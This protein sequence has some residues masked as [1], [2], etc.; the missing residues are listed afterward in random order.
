MAEQPFS[1]HRD[2]FKFLHADDDDWDEQEYLADATKKM[3]VIQ[4][5][6]AGHDC[7][8]YAKITIN[9]E[10]IK[11]QKNGKGHDRGVHIVIINPSSGKVQYAVVFDTYEGS[12]EFDDF[13]SNRIP[14]GYIVIAACKDDCMT[15]LSPKGKQFFIDLGSQE[16]EKL[17]YR[18]SFALIAVVGSKHS[19]N[20]KRG[21]DQTQAVQVVQILQ[22]QDAPKEDVDPE[23][24]K[25]AD[26][27]S[28]SLDDFYDHLSKHSET[29]VPGPVI[30]K[31]EKSICEMQIS[32]E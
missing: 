8:N 16:I 30:D 15:K 12:E 22:G 25:A 6:S 17:S 14:T 29:K 31:L 13:V 7:G 5:Q 19:C 10:L 23:I 21:L 1:K 32:E 11:F 28:E 26:Q 20:E 2:I 18:C 3:F 27:L 4:A 24:L 9:D